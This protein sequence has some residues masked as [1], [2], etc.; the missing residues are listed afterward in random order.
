MQGRQCCTSELWSKEAEKKN[1]KHFIEILYNRCLKLQ[2]K[3]V[4]QAWQLQTAVALVKEPAS[5]NLLFM[6]A[7]V[8]SC[9][10]RLFE[11]RSWGNHKAGFPLPFTAPYTIIT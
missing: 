1:R 10:A 3:V 2:P 6:L 8:V 4:R 7:K 9:E 5:F 11:Q